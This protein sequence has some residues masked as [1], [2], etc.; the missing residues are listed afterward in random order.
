MKTTPSEGESQSLEEKLN[1]FSI[2]S[3][4]EWQAQ[5]QRIYWRREPAGREFVKVGVGVHAKDNQTMNFEYSN[6]FSKQW[7]KPT[8]IKS[9]RKFIRYRKQVENWYQ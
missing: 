6:P 9:S 1:P 5:D 2:D 7:V 3:E 8:V 4:Q